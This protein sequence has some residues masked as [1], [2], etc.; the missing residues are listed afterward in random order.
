MMSA[1][2]RQKLRTFLALSLVSVGLWVGVATAVA[3][4]KPAPLTAAERVRL[5]AGEL[6]VR[7]KIERRGS[8]R[9]VGGT[10]WQVIDAPPSV[11]WQ[12]VLDTPHYH[13]MLPRVERAKVVAKGARQR[14]VFLEHAAGPISAS[15]FL[16]V[17]TYPE[18]WDVTFVLDDTRPHS[19]R[20][21][22]G[23]YS[24]RAYGDGKTLLAYG[25]M[26]DVGDGVLAALARN[27]VQQWTL[28][29]PALIKR[30]V[31][32]SGRWIYR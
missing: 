23:F 30:F 2:N 13:R 8:L 14:T 9:L 5:S 11:V 22:W 6:V 7:S 32:N 15:Y 29:V 10:S 1:T 21:A 20:A 3:A 17:R 19:V 24:I 27:K 18:R 16:K 26:V 28:R 25:A 31:E 12:A 4:P